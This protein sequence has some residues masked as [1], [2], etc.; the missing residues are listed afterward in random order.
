MPRPG[1]DVNS[2][3]EL[4]SSPA[5]W[6]ESFPGERGRQD[7]GSCMAS[8]PWHRFGA[9]EKNIYQ[10]HTGFLSSDVAGWF[11]ASY[12]LSFTN[13][14]TSSKMSQTIPSQWD[15]SAVTQSLVFWHTPSGPTGPAHV[16]ASEGSDP[17]ISVR[18][19]C[20]YIYRHTLLHAYI[21]SSLQGQYAEQPV[22][23][24][25]LTRV[26]KL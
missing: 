2:K 18:S 6:R 10:S 1:E 7:G 9:Q 14:V 12:L 19:V 21:I 4:I 16:Y 17:V 15:F 20:V 24:N 11:R 8:M 3:A 22:M 25:T 5:S 13:N 26:V 23:R